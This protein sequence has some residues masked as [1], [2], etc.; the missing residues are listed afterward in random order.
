M[1]KDGCTALHVAAWNGHRAVVE[2]LLA[3]SAD[4]KV[5]NTAGNTAFDLAKDDYIKGLLKF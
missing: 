1:A 3:E 4:I 2:L 5:K